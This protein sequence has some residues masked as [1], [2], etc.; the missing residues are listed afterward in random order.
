MSFFIAYGSQHLRQTS[1]LL[2][3]LTLPHEVILV[4]THST[5][6]RLWLL[7]FG[8]FASPAGRLRGRNEEGVGESERECE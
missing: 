4:H 1:V 2:L 6:L 3:T 5:A 7:V 8:I